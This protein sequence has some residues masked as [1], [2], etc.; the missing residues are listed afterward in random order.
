MK[1]F[2]Q[3]SDVLRFVFYESP[4]INVEKNESEGRA[5]MGVGKLMSYGNC[6][7]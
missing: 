3:E 7:R 2:T 1:G 5:R 4:S 6:E